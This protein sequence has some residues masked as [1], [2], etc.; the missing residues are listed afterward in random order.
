MNKSLSLLALGLSILITA[1]IK[2]K[3]VKIINESEKDVL[4]SSYLD[5][6]ETAMFKTRADQ[7]RIVS[8]DNAYVIEGEEGIKRGSITVGDDWKHLVSVGTAKGI[9]T[10]KAQNIGTILIKKDG[11]VNFNK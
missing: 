4:I 10:E 6:M 2:S 3:D 7:A 1:N 8:V 9:K 11:I 5:P